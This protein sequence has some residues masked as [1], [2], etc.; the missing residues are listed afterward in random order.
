M[1]ITW[2][3]AASIERLVVVTLECDK[4]VN[5]APYKMVR[6]KFPEGT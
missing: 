4:F 1:A 6:L 2:H 5:E 3:F